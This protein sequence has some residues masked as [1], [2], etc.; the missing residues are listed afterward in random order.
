MN[1]YINNMNEYINERKEIKK[2]NTS[3]ISKQQLIDLLSNLDFIAIE[4]ARI[5]FITGYNVI[6]KEN[7]KRLGYNIE[8]D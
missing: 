6:D 4:S 3:Y 1:E 2:V 7:V 5:N 8:I